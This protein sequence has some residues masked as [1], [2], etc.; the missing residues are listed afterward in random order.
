MSCGNARTTSLASIVDKGSGITG[1]YEERPAA[2][3]AL[4]DSI[5]KKLTDKTAETLRCQAKNKWLAKMLKVT[6]TNCD[7]LKEQLRRAAA[8]LQELQGKLRAI[9]SIVQLQGAPPPTH[10]AAPKAV[11]FIELDSSSEDELGSGPS[12]A[13]VSRPTTTR[14]ATTFP[15]HTTTIPPLFGDTPYAHKMTA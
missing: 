2:D 6:V 4:Y 13:A 7:S 3:D 14:K 5:S 9:Q 10:P 8:K 12:S 15:L 11:D 1:A